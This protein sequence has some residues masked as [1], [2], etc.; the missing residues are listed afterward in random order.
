MEKITKMKQ[1]TSKLRILVY[2]KVDPLQ[3][4]AAASAN[5]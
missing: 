5:L 3:T 4:T 1:K 2:K